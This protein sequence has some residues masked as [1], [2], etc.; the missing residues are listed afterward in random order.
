ME[1]IIEQEPELQMQ[2]FDNEEHFEPGLEAFGDHENFPETEGDLQEE[3]YEEEPESFEPQ[4]QPYFSNF[5]EKELSPEEENLRKIDALNYLNS[6]QKK[7]YGVS[8]RYDINSDLSALE[9]EV[10]IIKRQIELENQ[11]SYARTLLLFCANTL[12]FSVGMVNEPN[13]LQGWGERM[14]QELSL[15]KYDEVLAELCQKY[16]S[17]FSNYGPEIRLFF[18][19][20]MSASSHAYLNFSTQSQQQQHNIPVAEPINKAEAIQ[21]LKK[22]QF[23]P[24]SETMDLYENFMNE[25]NA[26]KKRGRPK[27]AK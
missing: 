19:L 18:L 25:I 26:E 5:A 17:K 21:A 20:A 8:R 22:P 12:E 27:K 15:Q 23:Q 11:T 6:I 7:G 10:R 16:A 9:T 3:N 1:P 24:S 14:R 4:E 13:V 2:S